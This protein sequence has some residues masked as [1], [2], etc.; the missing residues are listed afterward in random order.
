LPKARRVS[1]I[2][3]NFGSGF[4]AAA[5]L[6]LFAALCFNAARDTSPTYD[7]AGFMLCGYS[8]LARDCPEIPADNLRIAQMWMGLPLLAFHPKI[9]DSLHGEKNLVVDQNA[10]ELGA[11]FLFDPANRTEAMLL[12]SRMAVTAAAVILGW[13]LFAASRRLHGAAAGLLTLG[14][15]CLNPVI[16]SNSAVATTDMVT[17]LC[18]TLATIAYWR[19]IHRPTL[20]WTA[21]FGL[22]FGAL[23]STKFTGAVFPVIAAVLLAV[24]CAAGPRLL[25]AWRLVGVNAAAAAVA[26]GVI[27][28]VYGFHYAHGVPL[29]AS[30]WTQAHPGLGT[31]LVDLFRQGRL[32][33]EAYLFD[34][35]MFLWK[36]NRL[37][38]LMGRYSWVGFWSFFPLVLLFKTPPALM[39]ALGLAAVAA[40]L[41]RRRKNPRSSRVDLYGL[42]P[43]LAMGAIYGAVA[44]ESRFNVG[45][46]HILPVFPL[47]F[48]AAGAAVRLPWRRQ[49]HAWAIGGALLAGSVAEVL[50]ARPNYLAYVNEFGGGPQNGWRLFVDSSYD[51]G[52]DLPA[53][54]RWIDARASRP[55]GD[56]PVFFSYFG[57]ALIGHYGIRAVLLPQDT[58]RRALIPMVLKPGTYILSATMVQGIGGGAIRGPWRIEYEKAYQVLAG[59]V[60]SLALDTPR[61][62]QAFRLFELLR[63]S[64]LCAYLRMRQPDAWI[65]PNVLVYELDAGGL[66]EAL[67][68]PP[69]TLVDKASIP[70]APPDNL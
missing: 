67:F 45:I 58:E 65:T 41:T 1:I 64:R 12:A 61:G 21:A 27:W 11:E 60:P 66:T 9:P 7:E 6:G 5:M 48:V 33:P 53:I 20:A 37:T 46:R 19:L 32:L 44:V 28:L 35:H 38:F 22:G 30:V 3:F 31:K 25:R 18:F 70:G 17:V 62:A 24:R 59:R 8:Y 26:Y 52:Q 13:I 29:D 4:L 36:L 42:V 55:R 69:P 56:R 51:W 50:I 10:S 54:R 47:L 39:I 40:V 14:L 34:V 16:I 63:F 43:F 57:N 49:W 68:G 15:Y 2:R 23:L